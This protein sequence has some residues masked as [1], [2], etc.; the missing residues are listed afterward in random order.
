L[1]YYFWTKYPLKNSP[2][3]AGRVARQ[4]AFK[5]AAS[6]CVPNFVG[7]SHWPPAFGAQ[8]FKR[9][10]SAVRDAHPD[11]GKSRPFYFAWALHKSFIDLGRFSLL[12]I[13]R[14]SRTFEK[15]F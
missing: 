2:A 4:T 10:L 14:K 11:G 9:S 8:N 7:I 13:K 6:H 5:T 12:K 3:A 15:Y 1:S